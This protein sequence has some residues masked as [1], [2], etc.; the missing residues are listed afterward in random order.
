MGI[1]C[2]KAFGFGTM[3]MPVLDKEDPTSFDFEAIE[4]LFDTFLAKGFTYFDTAYTYH[5]YECEKAVRRAL[6]ERHPRENF[7]LATKL[8]L[9]DFKDA[10]DL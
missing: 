6:V 7:E 9:R 3:R 8:P 2:T 1:S 5:G 10:D 4:K